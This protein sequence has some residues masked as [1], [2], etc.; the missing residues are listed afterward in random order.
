MEIE[1]DWRCYCLA[2]DTGLD[3]LLFVDWS[4]LSCMQN[5]V[6]IGREDQLLYPTRFCIHDRHYWSENTRARSW[7]G[8]KNAERWRKERERYDNLKSHQSEEW[9]DHALYPAGWQTTR[10]FEDRPKLGDRLSWATWARGL[11]AASWAGWGTSTWRSRPTLGGPRNFLWFAT[12]NLKREWAKTIAK[13][14][15]KWDWQ[16]QCHLLVTWREKN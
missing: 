16:M 9:W 12:L 15:Q 5:Q 7:R 13:T 6:P 1:L 4:C 8:W 11:P 2:C 3:C 14:Q 10:S